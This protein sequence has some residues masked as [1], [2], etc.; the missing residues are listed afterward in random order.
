MSTT[1]KPRHSAPPAGFAALVA[2]GRS[3]ASIAKEL[4]C[5]VGTVGRWAKLPEV[6]AEIE[7]IRRDVADAVREKLGRAVAFASDALVRVITAGRCAACG[8]AAAD[9]HATIRASTYLLDRMVPPSRPRD[10]VTIP[11][12]PLDEAQ[13]VYRDVVL[14]LESNAGNAAATAALLRQRTEAFAAIQA[15]RESAPGD[16]F[17][18]KSAAE[19][20][21]LLIGYAESMPLHHL[22]VYAQVYAQR[23]GA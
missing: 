9:D 2:T 16:P 17:A 1:A 20:T 12:T 21:D 5:D 13:E 7:A 18:G 14:A 19:V 3:M 6:V 10:S 4:E 11:A 15:E 23:V 22:A 8:R